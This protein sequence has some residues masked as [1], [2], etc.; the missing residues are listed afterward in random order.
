M[1]AA[2]QL[3]NRLKEVLLDGTWIANTNFKEQLKTTSWQQATQK[4]ANLNTIAA[5][6][7]HINYYTAG[8]LHVCKGGTLEIRDTYSYQLPEIHS[9]KAWNNLVDRFL[10]NATEIVN[11]IAAMPDKKLKAPFSGDKY[12]TFSRNI[13]GL[14]EHSY[15]HLGQLVLLKKM[16][17]NL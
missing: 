4:L 17:I 5:L 1:T 11:C 14:I 13:E 16:S 3:S 7:F 10:C 12:G 15:Y 8:I 6:T 2:L 9:E